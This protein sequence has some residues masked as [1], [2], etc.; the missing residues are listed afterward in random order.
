[1]QWQKKKT[2]ITPALL[3][4]RVTGGSQNITNNNYKIIINIPKEN[5]ILWDRKPI[6]VGG[7]GWFNLRVSISLKKLY[8]GWAEGWI[9]I[10]QEERLAC[11][12]ILREARSQRVQGTIKGI[13]SWS[14]G[15]KGEDVWLEMNTIE[16]IETRTYSLGGHCKQEEEKI[17]LKF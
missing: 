16:V 4:F 3:E 14:A 7:E 13:C 17:Q 2:S 1:M 10:T 11:A 5:K 8:L 6:C 15:N 12:K 9:D